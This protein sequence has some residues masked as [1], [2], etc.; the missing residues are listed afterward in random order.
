MRSTFGQISVSIVA[1]TR[2]RWWSRKRLTDSA[3]SNGKY[4]TRAC[5]KS[6]FACAWPV[7]VVV[8]KT[9]EV[10]G[11]SRSISVTTG[12]AASV[13]PTDTA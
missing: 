7:I 6:R 4:V 11:R 1:K 10:C 5:G 3:K 9:I 12:F 13:S 8:V 2:G